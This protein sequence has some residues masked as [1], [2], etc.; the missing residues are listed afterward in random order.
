MTVADEPSRNGAE[1]S[2]TEFKRFES[3]T[4]RLVKVP[5]TEID[6]ARKKAEKRK[7]AP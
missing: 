5:K 3:F 7:L 4:K 6:K 1:P 2:G